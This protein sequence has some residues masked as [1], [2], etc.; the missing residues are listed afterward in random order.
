MRSSILWNILPC[1]SLEVNRCFVGTCRLH[2]QGRRIGQAGNFQRTTRFYI[3]QDRT[4]QDQ[5]S[6]EIFY[7]SSSILILGLH[8][9]TTRFKQERFKK[10]VRMSVGRVNVNDATQQALA[11]KNQLNCIRVTNGT[12]IKG[13]KFNSP[14]K[15]ETSF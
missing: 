4:L 2:L 5:L 8:S 9:C 10:T 11:T 12:D 7:R 15:T 13:N 6:R 3:P 1:S 14:M